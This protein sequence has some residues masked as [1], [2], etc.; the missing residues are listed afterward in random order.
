MNII[1]YGFQG[2]AWLYALTGD[3][4]KDMVLRTDN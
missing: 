1:D 2:R 4:L 3:Q